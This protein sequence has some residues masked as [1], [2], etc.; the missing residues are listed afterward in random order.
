MDHHVG[1]EG[2][3]PRAVGSAAAEQA[4]ES[5]FGV[6]K[7]PGV[8]PGERLVAGTFPFYAPYLTSVVAPFAFGFL[9]G[10]GAVNRRADGALGGLVVEKC[11]FLQESNCKGLCLHQCKR[12]AEAL[13]DELGV[14][15]HVSP[16]FATQ[17]CHWSWGVDA[18][19]VD[20]DPDWPAG[21]IAG[22]PSRAAARDLRYASG[23]VGG[24]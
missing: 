13:F 2:D 23:A 21:C 8:E 20:D 7:I 15:L 9:V 16:N 14:P 18:P 19:P 6:E 5:V 1:R 10:P 4:A 24:S 22:C 3:E 12:P 11:K 17:E